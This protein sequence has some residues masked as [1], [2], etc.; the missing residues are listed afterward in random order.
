MTRIFDMYR[1]LHE[2]AETGHELP[3]TKQLLLNE[4]EQTTA[5]IHQVGNSIIADFN[6]GYSSYIA[7]RS[8]MDGLP[9]H[10]TNDIP[11]RSIND[12]T[13]HAC[14]HDAHMA[15]LLEIAH[16]FSTSKPSH[17]NILLIFE[18]AEEC[19]GYASQIVDYLETLN[20]DIAT[21]ICMHVWPSLSYGKLFAN[22]RNMMARSQ[23]ITIEIFGES[24][25][26]SSR[27]YTNDALYAGCELINEIHRR[28]EDCMPLQTIYRFGTMQSGTV[29]N[30][31]SAYTN[32]QG[33][34]R[35]FNN[36]ELSK[37]KKQIEY[38]I[39]N[40]DMKYHTHT[41]CHYSKGY[42]LLRNDLTVFKRIR[43]CMELSIIEP[44]YTTESAGYYLQKYPGCYLLLGVGNCPPLH[45]P[46]FLVDE[47]LLEIGYSYLIS[48]A[49]M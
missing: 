14:G 12:M 28:I 26:I 42:P 8:E 13:M 6:F 44:Q 21:F 32:I 15:M 17:N 9:I 16:H 20:I 39:Q 48:L 27:H 10:E 2:L 49:E 22:P 41:K 34:C 43:N 7:F 11:F 25:H 30:A 29:R 23:E 3:K 36:R 33:S 5:T 35:S 4:L 37:L 1:H 19:D 46:N 18:E 38:I 45:S 40:I 31:T 47:E 24:T